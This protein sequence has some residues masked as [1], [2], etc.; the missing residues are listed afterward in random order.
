MRSSSLFLALLAS[1]TADELKVTQYDGPTECEDADKVK[2]GDQLGMHY[3][4]TID[5]SSKTGTAGKQF[6]SSRGRSVFETKIGVG[7][8]RVRTDPNA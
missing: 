7:Q 6:D 8:V 2:Q 4:G 1:A 3:T 5:A